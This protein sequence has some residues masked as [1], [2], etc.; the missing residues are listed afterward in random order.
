MIPTFSDN[1]TKWLSF[2]NSLKNCLEKNNKLNNIQKVSQSKVLAGETKNK[3]TL[4]ERYD[5]PEEAAEI[6]VIKS[7][8]LPVGNSRIII[9]INHIIIRMLIE[10]KIPLPMLMKA[11]RKQYE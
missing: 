5:K 7:V 4:K 6:L 1:L 2:W 3:R 8:D 9:D 10:K 11:K